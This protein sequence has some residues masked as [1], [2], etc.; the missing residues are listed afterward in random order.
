[1]PVNE[2]ETLLEQRLHAFAQDNALAVAW[3]NVAFDPQAACGNGPHLR[4]SLL[5]GQEDLMGIEGAGSRATGAF[6]VDVLTP[7]GAGSSQIKQILGELRSRFPKGFS[8]TGQ[9]VVVTITAHKENGGNTDEPPF[10][11]RRLDIL[12]TAFF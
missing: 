2:L 1:M 8:L 7:A 3:P 10:Y 11:K 9:Q 4:P 6:Q 5:M 12:F